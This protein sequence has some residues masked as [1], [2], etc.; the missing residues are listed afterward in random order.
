MPSKTS[1]GCS[2]Y[3]LCQFLSLIQKE[4]K[5]ESMH[6]HCPFFMTTSIVMFFL[7]VFANSQLSI[8]YLSFVFQWWKNAFFP[9][10][11]MPKFALTWQRTYYFSVAKFLFYSKNFARFPGEKFS[12]RHIW[13]RSF[14]VGHQPTYLMNPISRGSPPHLPIFVI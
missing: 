6:A 13:L 2:K 12:N 1:N 5:A 14:V 3:S 10:Y 8:A 11:F 4:L 7:F 9:F